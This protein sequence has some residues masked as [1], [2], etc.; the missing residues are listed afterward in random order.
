MSMIRILHTADLHLDSPL[1]SLAMRSGALRDRVKDASRR[2]L[3]RMVDACIEREARAMLI[4]GDLFDGRVRSARTAAFLAVQMDRLRQHGIQVF[5]IRGNHDAENPLGGMFELP[6]NVT[7]FDEQ[8]GRHRLGDEDIWIHGVSYGKAQ[9]PKSLLPKFSPPV[10]GAI[11]IAL[12]H[13]SLA[14]AAGHD[15]Y[16]PCSLA[17][18]KA[19]GF[20]YWALGHVH[21]RQVHAEAPW[22]VMPGTPQGR[23]MGEPGPKSAT[24]ITLADE[25]IAVGEIV[26]S[27]VEFR[28]SRCAIDGAEDGDSLRDLLREHLARETAATVSEAAILR[29]TLAG[30]TDLAWRILRDQD[31]WSETAAELIPTPERLWLDD[32]RFDVAA[33]AAPP[34]RAAD[35]WAE[36]ASLMQGMQERPEF[37]A[38]A[39]KEIED[40]LHGLP[41][42][43]R[44][45]LAPDEAAAAALQ[46]ELAAEGVRNMTA[47]MRGVG[48]E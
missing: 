37:A 13:S 6:G 19:A 2:A 18:L 7:I 5:C 21:R 41:G 40:V 10:A 46:G 11:N 44:G 24:L 34:S 38:F 27:S 9:A 16:A 33:A 29:L 23:D 12:L 15:P 48:R 43:C 36:M 20:D 22:V 1:R 25:G 39:K 4:A 47:R 45:R 35:P 8:G 14:G 26:T 30:R 32:V 28:E 42:P 31:E 3:E 17:E